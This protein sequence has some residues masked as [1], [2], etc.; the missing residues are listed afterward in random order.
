MIHDYVCKRKRES[1]TLPFDGSEL[2][3]LKTRNLDLIQ[4][5]QRGPVGHVVWIQNRH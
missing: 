3:L 2:H 4:S 5:K 1:K